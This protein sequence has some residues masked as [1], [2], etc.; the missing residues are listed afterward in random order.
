MS[1]GW[2]TIIVHYDGAGVRLRI[3][4]VTSHRHGG[5]VAVCTWDDR[6]R[7]SPDS[8]DQRRK[9]VPGVASHGLLSRA[10]AS[11]GPAAARVRDPRTVSESQLTP[12]GRI[13]TQ[14]ASQPSARGLGRSTLHWTSD[15]TEIWLKHCVPR[16]QY[17]IS[18][19]IKRLRGIL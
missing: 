18:S 10:P 15:H 2:N 1:H 7:T 14:P 6:S 12:A 13:R 19:C 5:P 8:P 3:K 17:T 11:P 16:C 9:P 4:S